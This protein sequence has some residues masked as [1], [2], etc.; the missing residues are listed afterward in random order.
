[1]GADRNTGMPLCEN[2]EFAAI[3]SFRVAFVR[4]AR[5]CRDLCP[6]TQQRG[7]ISTIPK[8][9]H[10]EGEKK[11]TLEREVGPAFGDRTA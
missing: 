6:P 7:E 8:T 5:H 10:F 4:G 3:L 11:H 9:G 2:E 1:M